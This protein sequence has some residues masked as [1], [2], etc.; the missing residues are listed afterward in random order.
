MHAAVPLDFDLEPVRQRV[1][2]RH[3]DA[4]QAAGEAVVLA[5][6]LAAGMELGQYELDARQLVLRMHV[7]GH[8][9]TVVEHLDG[10]VRE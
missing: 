7:H 6:E 10:P 2:H 8:A 5:V 1:Y 9:A 4:V 3:A